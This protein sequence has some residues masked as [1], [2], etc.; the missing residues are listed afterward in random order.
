MI[1]LISKL[2]HT[3]PL[4]HRVPDAGGILK[5]A[6]YVMRGV[7]FAQYTREWF[8]FLRQ[9]QLASLVRN[10]PYV[11]HK[12]QRPYLNSRLT[13]RERLDALE[14][15]YRFVLANF[16]TGMI[17]ALY[18]SPGITLASFTLPELGQFELL[19][20]NCRRKQKEGD[21]AVSIGKKGEAKDMYSLSFSIWK[22]DPDPKEIFIGGLQGSRAAGKDV[23]VE[24][25]RALHGLRPKALLIFLVQQLATCWGIPRL[26]AVSDSHHIYQHFQKRKALHTSYD[27]FWLECGGTLSADG[28]FDLPATFVP[29]K[30]AEL[31]VNKRQ[32]YRRRYE[33]LADLA[34][35]I[36]TGLQAPA[37]GANPHTLTLGPKRTRG[38]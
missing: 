21:F 35:K 30:I 10:H 32:M 14:G 6:K 28:M 22:Y 36:R 9:P 3:A 24:L 26:R 31:K 37:D 20:A 29:R 19:L 15:H 5:R 33:M 18:G 25:T 8:D 17:E 16:S 1:R 2:V 4:V 13:T 38:E 11:Y 34:E 23:V 27:E 12:L 7:A